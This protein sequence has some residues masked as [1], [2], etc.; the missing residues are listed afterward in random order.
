MALFQ[1]ETERVLV[2]SISL[3]FPGLLA[4]CLIGLWTALAAYLTPCLLGFACALCLHGFHDACV[5]MLLA[6]D[7]ACNGLVKRIGPVS[8]AVLV[9]AASLGGTLPWLSAYFE[10]ELVVGIH[11]AAALF[12]FYLSSLQRTDLAAGIIS[13]LFVLIAVGFAAFVGFLVVKDA[14]TAVEY[15]KELIVRHNVEERAYAV[16]ENPNRIPIVVQVRSF[17]NGSLGID[18]VPYID[19][20]E[21][22][23]R[24]KLLP[25]A[26]QK[27]GSVAQQLLLA[28]WDLYNWS[29]SLVMFVPTM[30]LS[31]AHKTT[32]VDI[33]R[34]VSPFTI[35]D[36]D[37][38]LSVL[39][40]SLLHLGSAFLASG[41][42]GG[43]S[44]FV[45]FRYL[46]GL[47]KFSMVVS[48]L[49]AFLSTVPLISSW[50]VWVPLVVYL[51]L[52]HE[53][54]CCS[55]AVVIH[56]FLVPFIADRF[57]RMRLR[58]S[59]SETYLISLT[60]YLCLWSFGVVGLLIG[61]IIIVVLPQLYLI[62][63]TCVE[64]RMRIRLPAGS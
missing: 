32:V 36:T 7:R 21:R 56:L 55:I 13:L 11:V 33:L 28:V 59:A 37:K 42:L 10:L 5:R 58:S 15:S 41:L 14:S 23:Y 47:D 63:R 45:T 50:V 22:Y 53:Y 48:L 17:V 8:T 34:A 57:L 64:P 35:E 62:L 9:L 6:L 20:A 19:A 49:S 16:L 40:D 4:A 39:R 1:D 60:T 54:V 3:L 18:P 44:T 51:F 31:L 25:D 52:Q 29:F 27:T 24:T 43:A 2:S 26:L 61:P 12:L 30:H 46:A 38:L